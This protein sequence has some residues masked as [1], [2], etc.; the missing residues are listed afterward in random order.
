MIQYIL[1]KRV[2]SY[3]HVR[4][5]FF[6]ALN[7]K[8]VKNRHCHLDGFYTFIIETESAEVIRVSFLKHINKTSV[9][10]EIFIFLKQKT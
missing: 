3:Q 1:N 8:T 2:G 6:A 4:K 10:L 9:V 7:F 5:A